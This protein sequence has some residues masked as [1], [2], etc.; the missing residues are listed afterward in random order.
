MV[1]GTRR[2]SAGSLP[3][4]RH[5]LIRGDAIPFDPEWRAYFEGRRRRR[6]AR[7]AQQVANPADC[8]PKCLV[9]T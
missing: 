8:R 2:F 7:D 5:V 3:I 1:N 4:R 9:L 6:P